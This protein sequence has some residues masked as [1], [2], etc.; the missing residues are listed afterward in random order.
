[1]IEPIKQLTKLCLPDAVN[2]ER[3]IPP[4]PNFIDYVQD[5]KESVDKIKALSNNAD[6]PKVVNSGGGETIDIKIGGFISFD[7]VVMLSVSPVFYTQRLHHS[8]LPLKADVEITFRMYTTSIKK[9]VESMYNSAEFT[10]SVLE[11]TGGDAKSIFGSIKSK[12]S[13]LASNL[14]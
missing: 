6:W 2:G 12:I 11:Q 1:M 14:F 5:K 8:G 10:L 9:Q 4:G 13:S 3:F 7:N